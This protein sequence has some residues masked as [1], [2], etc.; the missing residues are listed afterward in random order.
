MVMLY[1]S[2]SMSKGAY[3]RS[4]L[5]RKYSSFSSIA[6]F[7]IENVYTKSCITLNI[8]KFLEEVFKINA[9]CEIEK[10]DI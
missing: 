2:T 8:K 7:N 10:T 5:R 1:V 9:T 4:T 6:S 3:A